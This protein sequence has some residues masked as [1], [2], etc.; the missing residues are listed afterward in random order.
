MSSMSL[1][2]EW[3]HKQDEATARYYSQKRTTCSFVC[4]CVFNLVVFTPHKC[5][6]GT[7]CVGQCRAY[8]SLYCGH[9]KSISLG[10]AMLGMD[11]TYNIQDTNSTL[12]L[13]AT[14]FCSKGCYPKQSDTFSTYHTI[15]HI[16]FK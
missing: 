8:E 2:S 14:L 5:V 16:T 9:R 6:F 7:K 13:F 10:H 4:T 12:Y 3:F 15:T 11:R 1:L